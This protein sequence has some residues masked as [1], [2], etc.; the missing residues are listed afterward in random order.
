MYK[1]IDYIKI[2]EIA[3]KKLLECDINN[4]PASHLKSIL[5]SEGIV[6]SEMDEDP[7]EFVGVF[8][9][10]EHKKAIII[11]KNIP[12][13]GRKF[14]TIAHELGHYFL[15]HPLTDGQILCKGIDEA[16]NDKRDPDEIEANAFASFLLM[17]KEFVEPIMR[18]VLTITDRE[19][20]GN[21]YLD[22]QPC[23]LR[24]WEKCW[25]H[26]RLHFRTSKTCIKWRL[27][28]LGYLVIGE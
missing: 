11:N 1:E 4:C 17:P 25:Q 21:V 28:R 13:Q 22:G 7:D 19:H 9:Q 15:E 6:F 16:N 2:E 26:M 5:D 8:M 18:N 24:D 3:E 20:I 10:S 12:N 23:N 14:F 27:K